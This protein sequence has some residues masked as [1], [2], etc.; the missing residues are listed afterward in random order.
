VGNV[1]VLVRGRVKREHTKEGVLNS[2]SS[3]EE[4]TLI[5]S[6]PDRPGAEE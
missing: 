6:F 2:G 5:R 1:G 3:R 4:A